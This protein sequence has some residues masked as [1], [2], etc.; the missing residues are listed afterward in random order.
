MKIHV[1]DSQSHISVQSSSIISVVKNVLDL[2]AISCQ[3]VS[4]HLVDSE[5]ISAL[6]EAFFQDPTPTDCISFPID[7]SSSPYRVLGE[8]FVCPAVAIEYA[9]EHKID[10]LHE[11]T[12]YLVHGLLHLLGY[13]DQE[14]EERLLMRKMEQK[15]MNDL[16][17]NRLVLS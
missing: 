8:V 12:L 6:H 14:D 9:R 4:V 16:Q 15:H 5:E 3:E 10:P 7:S 17:K 2:E 13:R 11:T 1:Y